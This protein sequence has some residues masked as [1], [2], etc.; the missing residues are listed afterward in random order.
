MS[1]TST[2]DRGRVLHHHQQ[3]QQTES[4]Q[5][6]ETTG[7][8]TIPSKGNGK[9]RF[10]L[11]FAAFVFSHVGLGFL[12]LVY[13]VFGA[14]LFKHFEEPFVSH[15]ASY[16][17]DIRNETVN[18][19]W[20]ET[21]KLNVLYKEN[22]TAMAV[23]EIEH[24]Q[25]VLVR[26]LKDGHSPGDEY[27]F[28]SRWSFT[29]SWVYSISIITT[30]GTGYANRPSTT[31]GKVATMIYALIGIPIMLLFL[32]TI[33]NL[34]GNA[35]KSLYR[36]CC[37][38]SN[39]THSSLVAEVNGTN[40]GDNIGIAASPI[41]DENELHHNHHHHHHHHLHDDYQVNHIPLQCINGTGHLVMCDPTSH[42]F[43]AKDVTMLNN[44][45]QPQCSYETDFVELEAEDKLCTT[46]ESIDHNCPN[47]IGTLNNRFLVGMGPIYKE[48]T[49]TMPTRATVR[50]HPIQP[51]I[52]DETSCRIET[53]PIYFCFLLVV[54]YM[55]SGAFMFYVWEGCSI[56]DG[57]YFC[58]VTLSTIGFGD[59]IPE[60]SLTANQTESKKRIILVVLYVLGGM[61]L[62]AMSFNIIYEQLAFK[63]RVLGNRFQL[64]TERNRNGNGRDIKIVS[65]KF[66]NSA[67]DIDV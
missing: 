3:Q 21:Y 19:L 30:I 58:F 44:S 22:W 8:T 37:M 5:Y 52:Y 29:D 7:G 33:G 14:F 63:L 55:L 47:K 56:L 48:S 42:T 27:K 53:V 65:N 15:S 54:L 9:I 57:A 34:L 67:K 36:F 20:T 4:K 28:Y 1:Y 64:R 17:A 13:T 41:G 46:T 12:V 2:T 62:I 26:A 66:I 38:C 16:I 49:G 23:K 59:I 35:L 31:E 39:E 24:F 18:K 25:R 11:Q 61:T 43:V 6:L 50:C 60:K 45:Y 32:S 40:G 51:A 10:C